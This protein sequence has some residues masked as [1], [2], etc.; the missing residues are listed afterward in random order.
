MPELRQWAPSR[1]S[2]AKIA[3][4]HAHVWKYTCYEI[5]IFVGPNAG[6]L[7]FAQIIAELESQESKQKLEAAGVATMGQS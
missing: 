7:L 4:F 3:R 1:W 2:P 5:V 6:N